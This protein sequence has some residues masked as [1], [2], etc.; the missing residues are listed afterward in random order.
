M[1]GDVRSELLAWLI[2]CAAAAALG[3]AVVVSLA[4]W[5]RPLAGMMAGVG[6]MLLSLSLLQAIRP[7][8]KRFRLPLLDLPEWDS[9]LTS[10][11]PAGLEQPVGGNVH[12]LRPSPPP[13]MSEQGRGRP[14][15]R[16]GKMDDNVVL[17]S[18]DASAA[19]RNSLAELRRSLP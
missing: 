13:T 16:A 5:G 15:R 3:A 18:A 17:L 19:L 14:N 12:W 2:D 6:V 7:E 9:I 11:E 10:D 8:P 4:W 1:T